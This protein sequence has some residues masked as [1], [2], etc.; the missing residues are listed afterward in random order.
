MF[1]FCARHGPKRTHPVRWSLVAL[2]TGFEQL[3]L[4]RRPSSPE[5]D[6]SPVSPPASGP[7]P[8]LG[9][10]QRRQP[11]TKLLERAREQ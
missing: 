9:A 4:V 2:R 5:E 11:Q 10:T 7:S 1:L 6:V 8:V 3:Q